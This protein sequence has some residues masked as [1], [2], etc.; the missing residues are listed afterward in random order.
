MSTPVW[1]TTLKRRL[2]VA[3]AVL[4]AAAD[5]AVLAREVVLRERARRAQ[6]A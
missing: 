4:V 5:H 1:R 6:A 2:I 3:A